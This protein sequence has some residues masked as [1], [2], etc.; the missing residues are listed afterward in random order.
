LLAGTGPVVAAQLVIPLTPVIDHVPNPVAATAALGPVTVAVNMIVEPSGALSAFALTTTL[1]VAA[2]TVV[3]SP[4][5]GA[6][7]K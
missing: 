3:V 7:A 2:V 1:G 6:V 5:V 4:D